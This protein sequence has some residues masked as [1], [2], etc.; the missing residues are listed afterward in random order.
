[1]QSFK[2]LNPSKGEGFLT[3]LYEDHL[4][5]FVPSLYFV[6][7]VY[8]KIILMSDSES[9]HC[10]KDRGFAEI[11]EDYSDLS[12]RKNHFIKTFQVTLV[13]E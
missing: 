7:Y 3:T 4:K 1:M 8:V 2:C 9:N 6:I 10:S 12:E 13:K 11:T 5:C